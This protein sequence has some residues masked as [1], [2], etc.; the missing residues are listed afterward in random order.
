MLA[1]I[2][3][4]SFQMN[5]QKFWEF[6]NGSSDITDWAITQ[7]L[8]STQNKHS[9]TY[10][11]TAG[12]NP[13]LD[14]TN[15]AI[16]AGD[17]DG[18]QA[19]HPASR[20]IMGIT[21]RVSASGPD[22]LV[23]SHPNSGGGDHESSL[24]ITKG[25]ADFKT[26]YIDLADNATKQ[27]DWKGTEND[28]KISFKDDA[29]VDHNSV[30]ETIEIERIEFV[31]NAWKGG[32]GNVN[33]GN[34]GNWVFSKPGISPTTSTGIAEDVLFPSSATE[35][36]LNVN[37]LTTHTATVAG[38]QTVVNTVSF[39]A[40]AKLNNNVTKNLNAVHIYFGIGSSF[41]V[42]SGSNASLVVAATYKVEVKD[43]N[44][45]FLTAPVIGEQ[46]DDAW[47]LANNIASGSVSS[48]NR[49]I[50]RYVNTTPNGTTGHWRYYQDMEGATEFFNGLGYGLKTN[51]SGI[52]EFIGTGIRGNSNYTTTIS[53]GGAGG[54]NWN[55]I[56]SQYTSHL[57]VA[58][59]ITDNNAT[60]PAASKAIYV[61]NGTAY[62]SLITGDLKV[63]QAFFINNDTNAAT[64]TFNAAAQSLDTDNSA[65]FYKSSD[66]KVT[67]SLTSDNKTLNSYISYLDGKTTGLN[68]GFD[69]SLFNGVSS[70]LSIYTHLLENNEG[71]NF[72]RQALP[73]TD[74]ES[75][76]IP[77]GVKAAAGKEIV[78]S[79]EA[80]NLPSGLKVF[81]E[82][83]L[84]NTFTRLDE[85]NTE[86]KIT[87]TEAIDGVG[88]FYLYTTQSAL[89]VDD[90]AQ[91]NSVSIYK[92][93][94]STLKIAGLQ[95]GKAS[96]SLFNIQG[97]QI[98]TSTFE[99]NGVKEI[100]LPNLATGVYLV[101]LTTETGKF[102]KK[103]ILE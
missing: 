28:I 23:V 70:N 20:R 103:I 36:N 5:A 49:G 63:G 86:Y 98:L 31:H 64:A 3:L 62:T 40:G 21:I 95:Q 101:Q 77:V 6:K 51:G 58:T 100:S 12:A 35:G 14:I 52:I 92:T 53:Q 96:V 82:D 80:S 27:A 33:W 65:V 16:G 38:G 55:L 24:E 9:V 83:R 25:D 46:Y 87:L 47:V 99:A 84:T 37:W 54:T 32:A 91:L 13:Q 78:F 11:T 56:G 67:L 59:F 60:L 81:L 45:H 61:W 22:Y 75:M 30:G 68:P 69:I 34:S 4:L 41:L 74:L 66:T 73:S 102:N 42:N 17:A 90:D 18:T 29:A 97:K 94:S 93:N 88:R 76:V 72:E 10:T 50:S 8:T 79:T 44:W 19:N 57:N 48:D 1:F 26:Y 85:A 71:I 7:F 43:S 2:G 39:G 89:S 15:A